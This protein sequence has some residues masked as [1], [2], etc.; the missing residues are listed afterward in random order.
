MIEI[1][2]LARLCKG[3]SRRA[4]M[5]G[6]SGE[7]A[8]IYTLGLWLGMEFFGAFF[9]SLIFGVTPIIYLFAIVFGAIGGFISYQISKQGSEPQT[10]TPYSMQPQALTVPCTVRVLYESAGLDEQQRPSF[11]LNGKAFVN[12]AAGLT[13]STDIRNNIISAQSGETDGSETYAFVAPSGGV[14]NIHY[15]GGLFQPNLTEIVYPD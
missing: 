4:V 3:N 13:L 12:N 10:T 1:F 11:R 5:R 15:I 2:T 7:I 6:S 14:I 8:V 9:A